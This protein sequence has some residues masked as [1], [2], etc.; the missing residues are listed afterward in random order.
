MRLSVAEIE[1]RRLPNYAWLKVVELVVLLENHQQEILEPSVLPSTLDKPTSAEIGLWYL[2]LRKMEREL[3]RMQLKKR[4]EAE[5]R[6]RLQLVLETDELS[7]SNRRFF[8]TCL[9]GLETRWLESDSNSEIELYKKI[10]SRRA[11]LEWG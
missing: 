5:S 9:S 10:L 2:E 1:K 7:K 6:E 3:A 4:F 11:K 8:Q